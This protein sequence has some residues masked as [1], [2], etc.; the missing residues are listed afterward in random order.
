MRTDQINLTEADFWDELYATLPLG[1]A[2][3]GRPVRRWIEQWVPPGRGS[4]FEIGCYPG[5]YLAVFGE[6]GYR[7]SGIDLTSLVTDRL[8]AWLSAM[9]YQLGEFNC[10]N[11][12]QFTKLTNDRYDIVCSF[13]FVEHFQEW[14]EVLECHSRLVKPGGLLLVSVPN[15]RGTIQRRLRELFDWENLARHNLE[16]MCPE[17][18]SKVLVLLGFETLFSGSFGRFDF[19]NDTHLVTWW[20]R[21]GFLGVKGIIPLMRCLPV[22]DLYA[23]HCGIV[24]RKM[25]S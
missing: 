3:K 7:L 16:A 22:S 11:F 21:F 13:G 23:P 6:L 25:E 19:W 1:V 15:F 20:Q 2:K 5:R 9:G 24:A 17:E 10:E 14:R 4:C 12:F 8:P 18:W